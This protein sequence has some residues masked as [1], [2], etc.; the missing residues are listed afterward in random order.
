MRRDGDT[1]TRRR[2][3]RGITLFEAVAAMTIIGMTAIGA[4]AAVGAGFRTAE[5]ARRALDAEALATNRLDAMDL[6]TDRELQALPDS[7]AEGVFPAPLNEYK[8][9][10]TTAPL[11]EQA[12]VY[13][14]GITITWNGG[15]YDITSYV[16]RRP[17]LLTVNR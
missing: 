10:T 17:P 14:V 12:G 5:R 16:Y 8:W 9:K 13:S 4:L 1:M 7:V 3:R 11:D 2:A 6:L 15:A